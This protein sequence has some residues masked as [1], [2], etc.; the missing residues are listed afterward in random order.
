MSWEKMNKA[1]L[2]LARAIA[3]HKPANAYRAYSVAAYNHAAQRIGHP[4][5]DHYTSVTSR[6]P[7]LVSKLEAA[8]QRHLVIAAS[9]HNE[10]FTKVSNKSIRFAYNAVKADAEQLRKTY[11]N[12]VKATEEKGE[13]REMK[14]SASDTILK[15]T[16]W[17]QRYVMR[18]AARGCMSCDKEL[19][20]LCARDINEHGSPHGPTLAQVSEKYKTPEA[21]AAAAK[22]TSK[23][24]DVK[25]GISPSPDVREPAPEVSSSARKLT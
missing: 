2:P 18:A 10:S 21:L 12:E 1:V 6:H 19:Y 24:Y 23:E 22:R 9:Q 13:A 4:V 11:V 17:I 7:V 20:A 5:G 14:T 3:A 8:F 15:E 16:T 25:A